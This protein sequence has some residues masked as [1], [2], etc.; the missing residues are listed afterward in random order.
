MFDGGIFIIFLS[1]GF[2]SILASVK[3]GSWL[4]MVGALMF[5]VLG[6]VMT[7]E[8]DVGIYST[9]DDG[10]IFQNGT[11]YIIGDGQEQTDNQHSLIGWTF[12]M[13]GCIV[14]VVFLADIIR[15][16]F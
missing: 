9:A 2:I 6:I 16:G 10:V 14:S 15:H 1:I 13:L 4:K 7:A 3:F 12:I 8:Y 11:M 5:F